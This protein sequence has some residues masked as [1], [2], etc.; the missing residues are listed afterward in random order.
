MKKTRKVKFRECALMMSSSAAVLPLYSG[1]CVDA[2]IGSDDS[3]VAMRRK[4]K[5]FSLASKGKKRR[6]V[7]ILQQNLEH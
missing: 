2:G 1:E 5:R 7:L 6:T 4:R 3:L